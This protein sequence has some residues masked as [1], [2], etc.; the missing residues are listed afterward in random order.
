VPCV[1]DTSRQLAFIIHFLPSGVFYYFSAS[2]LITYLFLLRSISS[3]PKTN[4]PARLD[5]ALVG[6]HGAMCYLALMTIIYY[7]FTSLYFSCLLK[8]TCLPVSTGRSLV[9]AVPCFPSF[10]VLFFPS[11]FFVT[12]HSHK[13]FF[14]FFFNFSFSFSIF[15]FLFLFFQIY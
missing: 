9:T 13:E 8:P 4:L 7:I 11:G 3:H 6:N 12:V 15:L 5:W 10:I 1:S 14:L 2:M